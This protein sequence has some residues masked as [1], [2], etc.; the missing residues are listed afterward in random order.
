MIKVDVKKF[1]GDKGL[2]G[3]ATLTIDEMIRVPD[4]TIRE[5][6]NGLFVSM[7]SKKVKPYK[8]YKDEETEWKETAYPISKEARQK[9]QELILNEFNGTSTPEFRENNYPSMELGETDDLPF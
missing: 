8:N 9:L 2:K 7:P 3:F 6:Q 5:G 1:D 4:F